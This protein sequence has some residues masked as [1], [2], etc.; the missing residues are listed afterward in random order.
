MTM[1]ETIQTMQADTTTA[2][3]ELNDFEL[4]AI[5]GGNDTVAPNLYDFFK[6]KAE[7]AGPVAAFKFHTGHAV[8]LL[9]KGK[10]S[11]TLESIFDPSKTLEFVSDN[12]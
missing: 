12:K 11:P 8:T 5:A 3:E 4:D 9:S 6:A 7:Q 2:I 1:S 10:S